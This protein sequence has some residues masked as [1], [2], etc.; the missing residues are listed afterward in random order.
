MFKKLCRNQISPKSLF[1]FSFRN[2]APSQRKI[3]LTVKNPFDA[4]DKYLQEKENTP[5]IRDLGSNLLP[6]RPIIIAEELGKDQVLSYKQNREKLQIPLEKYIQEEPSLKK[7]V[8][9]LKFQENLLKQRWKPGIL[10]TSILGVKVG[11]IHY[12]DHYGNQIPVTVVHVPRCVVT[13]IKPIPH[14]PRFEKGD[15]FSFSHLAHV[16]QPLFAVQVSS[17]FKH[18]TKL[19]KQL[20]GHYRNV[21]YNWGNQY[22][23]AS[24]ETFVHKDAL[25]ELGT[26]ITCQHFVPGQFIDVKA[27]T[28]GKGFQGAVKK[29]GFKGKNRTHGA[30]RDHRKLGS[31]GSQGIAKTWKGKKMAG[32]MGNSKVTQFNSWIFAVDPEKNTIFIKGSIPGHNGK[33]VLLR[34]AI[35]KTLKQ[36]WP[37]PCPSFSEEY[38]YKEDIAE[39]KGLI[40]H[41]GYPSKFMQ[42]PTEVL[43]QLQEMKK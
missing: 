21:P 42:N 18:E 27:I 13:Q 3:N 10:R 17:G 20:L 6:G 40:M 36:Q 5:T 23:S 16:Q 43:A 7:Y 4:F 31:T 41:I 37:L 24:V 38:K 14:I 2:Y 8:E 32:R 25:P 35:R 22:P 34:D 26:E 28:T 15:P 1:D 33:F 11:M 39:E 29:W 12:W 19:T 30:N 9:K